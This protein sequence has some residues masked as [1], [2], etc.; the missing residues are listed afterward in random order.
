M[1]KYCAL[2]FRYYHSDKKA[3]SI[4]IT[5]LTK[6]SIQKPKIS[7]TNATKR[8]KPTIKQHYSNYCTKR[9]HAASEDLQECD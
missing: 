4:A 5:R 3:T 1:V 2:R 9:E 8:N 7:I 6:C